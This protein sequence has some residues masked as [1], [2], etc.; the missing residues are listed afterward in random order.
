MQLAPNRQQAIIW[1]NADP[2]HWRIYVALGGDEL[3][4]MESH[5]GTNKELTMATMIETTNINKVMAHILKLST[6]DK[7]HW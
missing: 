1:T 4:N 3:M 7:V 2:I 6:Y 5:C